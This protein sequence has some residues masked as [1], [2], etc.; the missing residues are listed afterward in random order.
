MHLP[1]FG[2]TDRRRYNFSQLRCRLFRFGD[3][4]L[5]PPFVPAFYYLENDERVDD[6]SIPAL[7]DD[8]VSPFLDG[9]RIA[10]FAALFDGDELPL[11]N[12]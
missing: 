12:R 3:S 1:V 5:S 4:P 9:S 11:S 8:F 2:N 6:R 10:P 7:L